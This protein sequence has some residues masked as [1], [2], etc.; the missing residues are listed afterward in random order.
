MGDD[1]GEPDSFQTPS[2]A[3]ELALAL[4]P[5]PSAMLSVVGSSVII[6]M[7]LSTRLQRKWTPYT[8]LLLC[9]SFYDIIASTTLGMA[10]F[11]RDKDTSTRPFSLGSSGT[12]TMVG[13]SNQLSYGTLFYNGSLSL[14]FLLT[15]RF[16]YSNEYIA[17]VVEPWMHIIGNGFAV[18]TSVVALALGAYGEM[19]RGAGCWVGKSNS[20]LRMSL[21]GVLVSNGHYLSHQLTTHEVAAKD[22][23]VHHDCWDGST[24]VCLQFASSFSY[25]FST[26]LFWCL[27]ADTKYHKS[28]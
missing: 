11:L 21:I 6:Y 17:R 2:R 26:R 20:V 7:S 18:S 24:L 9:L 13:F 12:C 3:Q 8:R 27:S 14:Y 5:I 4:L 16:G 19:T 22:L 28:H 1:I 23:N 15:V 25:L 10:S